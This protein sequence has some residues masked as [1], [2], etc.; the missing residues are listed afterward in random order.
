MHSESVAWSPLS[1]TPAVGTDTPGLCAKALLIWFKLIFELT[2]IGIHFEN[3][4]GSIIW[5]AFWN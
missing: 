2:A 5:S 1:E 4:D 3:N